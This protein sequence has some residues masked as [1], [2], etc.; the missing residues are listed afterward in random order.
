MQLGDNF[1]PNEKM[2]INGNEKAIDKWILSRLANCVQL[3]NKGPIL[4]N[5]R[6]VVRLRWVVFDYPYMITL[7]LIFSISVS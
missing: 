3:C 1:K 7:K 5:L 4:S 6:V 2:G